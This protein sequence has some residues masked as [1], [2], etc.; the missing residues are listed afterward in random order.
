MVSGCFVGQHD[1]QVTPFGH[2]WPLSGKK[3]KT[4]KKYLQ[5]REF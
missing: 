1:I 2:T 3:K 5:L 4:G